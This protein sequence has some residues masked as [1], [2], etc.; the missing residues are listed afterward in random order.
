M[1]VYT[2][3]VP[4][5]H[6]RHTMGWV[7]ATIFALQVLISFLVVIGGS[8]KQLKLIL[9]RCCVRCKHRCRK[10]EAKEQLDAAAAQKTTGPVAT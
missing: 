5:P 4:D 6:A 1:P 10:R 2:E 9:K 8:L 3:F 7:S